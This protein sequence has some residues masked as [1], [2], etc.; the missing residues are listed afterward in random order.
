MK[1]NTGTAQCEGVGGGGL[2]NDGDKG[3]GR[4]VAGGRGKE[5][6]GGGK[7]LRKRDER[8]EDRTHKSNRNMTAPVCSVLCEA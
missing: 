6:R 1:V 4:G 8:R 3:G 5:G 7:K 2:R